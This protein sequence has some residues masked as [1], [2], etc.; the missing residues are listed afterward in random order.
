VFDHYS[1]HA[2]ELGHRTYR[3]GSAH[4]FADFFPGLPAEGLTVTCDR[5]QALSREDLQFL[6]WDHPLVTGALD[7][8]LGS[9]Q[10][11]SSFARWPDREHAGLYLEAI[12]VLEC[13]APAHLHA[14]RF[15]PATPLRVLVD[16][17]GEDSSTEINTAMLAKVLI[18][19]NGH[20]LLER[21]EF[22]EE[23]LP[24][25]IERAQELATQ[26]VTGIVLRARTSMATQLGHEIVRLNEL[27]KANR[28]VRPEEI[29]LLVE[30]RNALD[31]H[32]QEARLRLDAIRLIQRG[33]V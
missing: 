31:R 7:L 13:I 2:E 15:L 19:G 25:L 17:R 14:D 9:E 6:T 33:P 23:L 30:Q 20:T 1:I 27:Q 24:N 3:L 8:L 4:V 12:V 32:L 16:H 22:R 5:Q 28:S 11:N 29:Q 26:A 10:G 21:S 18:K